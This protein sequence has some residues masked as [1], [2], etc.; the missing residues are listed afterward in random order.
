MRTNI[1]AKTTFL[2]FAVLVFVAIQVVVAMAG[3]VTGPNAH[4]DQVLANTTDL[5]EF[6][7]EGN[8]IVQIGVVGNG[9]TDLDLYV[10][11][12]NDNLIETDLDG[13]DLCYAEWTPSWTGKFTIKIKN[14]GDV[15]ND[16]FLITN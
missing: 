15:Y 10:Y 2:P 3:D 5:Y 7:F 12:E 13:S 8:E 1:L 16:Y 9:D 6:T 14:L 11:D 4:T